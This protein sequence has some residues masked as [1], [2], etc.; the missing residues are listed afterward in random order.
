MLWADFIDQLK[1]AKKAKM[2]GL[3]VPA[4][5]TLLF[6]GAM[7]SMMPPDFKPTVDNYK[8]LYEQVKAALKSKAQD[9]KSVV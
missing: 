6:G 8:A 9:R 1:A 2:K 7:D 4:I 5:S 3:S